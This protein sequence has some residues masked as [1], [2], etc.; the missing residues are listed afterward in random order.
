M[1]ALPEEMDPGTGEIGCNTEQHCA[2]Q[3]NLPSDTQKHTYSYHSNH[4]RVLLQQ[5]EGLLF[6]AAV[7]VCQTTFSCSN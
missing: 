4:Q 6:V 7:P 5:G 1:F 3:L 2:N